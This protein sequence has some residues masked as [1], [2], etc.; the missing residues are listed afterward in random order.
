MEYTNQPVNGGKSTYTAGTAPAD[1]TSAVHEYRLD[2]DQDSTKFYVDG[3]LQ[4]TM[5]TNVP[6]K[7]G[8]WIWNNW[9]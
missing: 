3:V 8:Y 4:Q 9:V 1:A 2:W 7:A 6:S 5:T